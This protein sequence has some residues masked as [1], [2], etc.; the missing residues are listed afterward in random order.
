MAV[1]G[2]LK[3]AEHSGV[4]TLTRTGRNVKETGLQSTEAAIAREL[5]G[6]RDEIDLKNTN[7]TTVSRAITA[8]R[9]ALKREDEGVYF[10]S[11]KGWFFSGLAIMVVSGI[12]AAMLSDDPAPAG[13][14]LVWLAAWTAGTAH[15]LLQVYGA[16]GSVIN[17]PGSRI[18]NFF[19]A[20]F[21]TAFALPFAAGLIFGVFFLGAI[22]P[23]LVVGAVAAQGILATVFYR[24]LKAPTL[25][26]AKIR[27]QIDGFRMFLV[28]AEQKRL[29]ILHPPQVTPEVFEKFLPYAIALDAENAWSHIFEAEAAKA[30]TGPADTHYTPGWYSGPSLGRLSTASFASGIGAAVA[31]ATAA[32][33]TAPGS[34]SGSGGGGSSGGGGGGGGGGGW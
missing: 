4:Y 5:F 25:A 23:P 19:G 12:A 16:W 28:T 3:I 22:L 27:D 26:G 11:N 10:V 18:L 6:A 20:L 15:L 17:G 14:I 24:L 34:S 2:Y 32:A 33:A 29:E 31:T 13:F 9:E 21:T 7:H 8:L 1:K 30:A